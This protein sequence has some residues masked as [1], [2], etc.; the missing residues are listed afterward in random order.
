[1][2][3]KQQK[4]IKVF[5]LKE[6]GKEKGSTLFDRQDKM[7]ETLIKNTTNKSKNQMK[8]L[9]QI[10]RTTDLQE[11]VQ[12]QEKDCYILTQALDVNGFS[13]EIKRA[14]TNL[15]EAELLDK[16]EKFSQ[17][18]EQENY[19]DASEVSCDM[20]AKYES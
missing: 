16:L 11:S 12:N 6:F 17:N 18:T 14:H 20:R 9:V 15:Y 7:L 1:M 2:N 19:R 10:M 13:F 8:T 5:L 4:Q 3:I